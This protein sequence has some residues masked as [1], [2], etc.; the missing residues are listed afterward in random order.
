MQRTHIT[1]DHIDYALKTLDTAGLLTRDRAGQ[2]NRH[3]VVYGQGNPY[4]IA[5]ALIKLT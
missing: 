3:A 2:A 1:T 5:V 4:D